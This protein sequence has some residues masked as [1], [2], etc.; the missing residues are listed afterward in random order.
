MN[1]KNCIEIKLTALS[2]LAIGREKPGG[3]V[4][5]V[6]K[7]I[8]GSVLRGAVAKEILCRYPEIEML[9]LDVTDNN[10]FQQLFLG[11][12]PAIFQ[13]LYPAIAKGSNGYEEVKNA[14]IKVLPATAVSS[15]ANPGFISSK[16]HGVFDTLIDWFCADKFNHPYDPSSIN[17]IVDGV[18]S[19]VEAFN[20]FYTKVGNKYHSHAATSRFLTRV[21]IN[22]RR[23]TAAEDILYSIEV[24]NEEFQ[25]N[26]SRWENYVYRGNILVSNEGLR[27]K[28]IQFLNHKSSRFSLGGSTSRGLGKVKIEARESQMLNDVKNR[29]E[30]FN[31]KLKTRYQKWSDAFGQ[32]T[33]N[34]FSNNRQYFTINLHSEAI[35][36]ENWQRTTV[37]SANML[38]Q[39]LS[40]DD[41]DASL[42]L[43]AAYSS[44]DYRSGW[45]SAWGLMKDVELVTSKGSVYLF[46]ISSTNK[47]D[48]WYKALFNLVL[49]GIGERTSEGFGRVEICNEFHLVFREDAV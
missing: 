21:G 3:S 27:K 13:N 23:A 16:K 12:N 20:C 24:L 46:S 32:N 45:N 4:S 7:Y 26:S 1:S 43:H 35:L 41:N 40:V 2:P 36:S 14:A 15:K 30:I 28:L 38:K 9:P 6:E 47:I 11:E 33:N 31:S 39:V 22:R 37:I 10:D 44:Y 18:D 42:E 19:R 5:E 25:T 34:P 17:A 29:I 49:S 48:L 8:P